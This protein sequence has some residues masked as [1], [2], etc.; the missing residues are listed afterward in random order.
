VVLLR[1]LL[2]ALLGGWIGAMALF[3]GV[4][5]RAAF[6][7]APPETAGRLVGRVLGPLLLGGAAA[8]ITLAAL[9][10][11]LRRGAIAV[12]LPLLLVAAC[13]LSHFWVSPAVAAIQ[14]GDPGAGPD[15]GVRFARLHA[16]SM[17]LFLGTALGLV[18]LAVLHAWHEHRE[19]R[20]R[21]RCFGP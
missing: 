3:G 8:G 10:G 9:G 7:V 5:A 11:I 15:A 6:E 2:W 4:L 16:L 14:L 1:P 20:L 12:A 21:A 17:G 18:L 19:S 13:L